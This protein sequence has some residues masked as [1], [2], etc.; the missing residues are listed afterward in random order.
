MEGAGREI[1]TLQPNAVAMEKSNYDDADFNAQ[2][3][4]V[5]HH[6]AGQLDF[7]VSQDI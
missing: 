2:R 6:Y 1:A 4:K 7:K 5:L 3:I